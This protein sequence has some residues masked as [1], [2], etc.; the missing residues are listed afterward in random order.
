M[1]AKKIES[2]SFDKE[3]S[4]QK[5]IYENPESLPLDELKENIRLLITARE[6][7]TNSGPIDAV[8][9]DS[10]GEIYLIETKLY[11]N[12]DKR[13]VVAQVLDYGASL[14][15][16]E[17]DSSTF[18]VV[19]EDSVAENFRTGLSER[20]QDFFELNEDEAKELIENIKRN[21]SEGRFRFVVLMDE[22]EQRLKNLIRFINQYS[23]FDLFGVE[24]KYYK[25]EEYEIIIPKLY[26]AE[27]KKEVGKH[28]GS[29]NM[30]K[31]WD[32][33]SFFDEI[34]KNISKS[35]L[36]AVN[37]LYDF[38]KSKADKI[39]WGTGTT[40]GSF[41]PI[42]KKVCPRSVYTVWTYG[43]LSFNLRWVHD[44]SEMTELRDKIIESL[45]N[46]FNWGDCYWQDEKKLTRMGFEIPIEK[47]SPVVDKL[48]D[49]I[50]TIF[51]V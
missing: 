1:K 23:S 41:N 49:K 36:Q 27:V 47:W 45:K 28:A 21:F 26:G 35:E 34:S 48:I 14:T 18:L 9:F 13:K 51:S 7:P 25:F 20:L 42:F 37:K 5:Y 11:K 43:R 29:G 17:T 32:E 38:S 44:N 22:L 2:S 8:G 6:F 30:R 12:P 24:L 50:R 10:E 16:S 31:Q 40:T 3:G 39:N 19:I 46:D 4:L 15:F 33:N